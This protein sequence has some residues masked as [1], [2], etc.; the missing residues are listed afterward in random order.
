M[1]VVV[2]GI[3]WELGDLE[4]E[5]TGRSVLSD[6]SVL[7]ASLHPAFVLPLPKPSELTGRAGSFVGPHDYPVGGLGHRQR[8]SVVSLYLYYFFLSLFSSPTFIYLQ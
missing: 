5:V 8:A 4:E 1:T 3:S 2:K 7:R 6:Q